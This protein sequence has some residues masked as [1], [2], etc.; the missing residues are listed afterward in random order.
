[1]SK[2]D[3]MADPPPELGARLNEQV[4]VAPGAKKRL[5]DCTIEDATGWI[6]ATNEAAMNHREITQLLA[7]C[8]A[9]GIPLP[10][11]LHERIVSL[12]ARDGPELVAIR[13]E[14]RVLIAGSGS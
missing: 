12:T 10:D 13:N 2:L 5:G 14:L 9:E 6:E 7:R 8:T 11:A 1:V 3:D 4:E